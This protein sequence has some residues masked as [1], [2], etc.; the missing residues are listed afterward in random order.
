MEGEEREKQEKKEEEKKIDKEMSGRKRNGVGIGVMKGRGQMIGEG[1]GYI[2]REE[3]EEE[4]QEERERKE[5]RQR[6]E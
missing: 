2:E 1:G 5:D 6:D 3:R 4:P